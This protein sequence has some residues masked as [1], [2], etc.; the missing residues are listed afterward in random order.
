[1]TPRPHAWTRRAGLA[2]ALAA[3][4]LL[5]LPGCNPMTIFYF[6]QPFDSSIPAPGPSLKGKKVVVL[7]HVDP[8]SGTEFDDLARDLNREFTSALRKNVKKI[9]IV[10]A[11]KVAGW[12]E[13]HPSWTDPSEA[14]KAF[15][16][17]VAILLD[18]SKFITQDPRNLDLMEGNSEV[19][20][21][22]WEIAHPKN[23][24]GHEIKTQPKEA[25]M[26]YEEQADTTFPI[27]GPVPRDT[28]VSPSSFRI[29]FLK[30]V[31]T[32]LSWHF[33]DHAP[34]DDIQD[35]KFNQNQ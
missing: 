2:I 15:E 19:H 33:V 22:V 14:A 20:I 4:S 8:G 13:A 21:Q 10:E 35:V 17:D 11:D 23:S 30:L 29:K 24:R 31:G 1:M 27:R 9:Q 7:V 25:S 6:L 12:V 32:E 26:V 16:A 5:S 34:G 28:G 18:V 3:A